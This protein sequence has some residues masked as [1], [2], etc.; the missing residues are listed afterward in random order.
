MNT[1][2]K[3]V[4]WDN[5]SIVFN[6]AYNILQCH[7]HIIPLT[8]TEYRLCTVFFQQW[9]RKNREP[10]MKN[11]ELCILSYLNTTELQIQTALASKQLLR[12]HISNTNGKL[13]PFASRIKAFGVTTQVSSWQWAGQH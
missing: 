1:I 13:T 7:E 10:I 8:P 11:D 5:L 12:K 9:L 6:N 4:L 2:T 3:Y